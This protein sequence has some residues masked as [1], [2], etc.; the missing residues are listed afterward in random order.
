[1]LSEY[2]KYK[3]QK[4]KERKKER[5]RLEPFLFLVFHRLRHV[6]GKNRQNSYFDCGLTANPAFLERFFFHVAPVQ[7]TDQFDFPV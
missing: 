6:N 1:M 7:F 2:A 5:M 4:N 3:E